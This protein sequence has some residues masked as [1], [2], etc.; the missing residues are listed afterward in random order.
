MS[1]G[2]GGEKSVQI[3]Y[4][5]Q[6]KRE[7][8]VGVWNTQDQDAL[9]HQWLDTLLWGHSS[10]DELHDNLTRHPVPAKRVPKMMVVTS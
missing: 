3:A 1:S 9:T 6:W 4:V 8:T 5:L 2:V 7:A 10:R